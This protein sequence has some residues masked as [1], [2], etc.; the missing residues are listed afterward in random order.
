[1]KEENQLY[2]K[3][4]ALIRKQ[5]KEVKARLK[6]LG[7]M[8]SSEVDRKYIAQPITDALEEYTKIIMEGTQDS[9]KAGITTVVDA[10]KKAGGAN[11]SYLHLYLSGSTR[12]V[13]KDVDLDITEYSE[14]IAEMLKQ[15]T[16]E[17]SETTIERMTGEVMDNLEDSYKEGYGIDKASGELENVFTDMEDYELKRVARTEINGAQNRATEATEHELGI[18]YDQWWSASDD[19]VRGNEPDDIADHVHMHGQ[20]SKVGGQFSNGL[21]RPGDRTGDIAE[22]INCR[23]RLVPFLMPEGYVAPAMDYFYESDLIKIK[24]PKAVKPVKPKPKPEP[25]LQPKEKT[26][27]ML[28]ED[29][30]KEHSQDYNKLKE[31]TEKKKI[32]N[33]EWDEMWK[34]RPK[35]LEDPEGYEI[36]MKKYKEA[37]NKMDVNIKAKRDLREKIKEGIRKKVYNSEEG[38]DIRTYTSPDFDAKAVKKINKAFEEVTKLV[39]K[40]IWPEDVELLVKELGPR[41]RAYYQSQSIYVTAKEPVRIAVHEIGHFL[42]EHSPGLHKKIKAFYNMRTADDIPKWLGS[43]Y[44]PDEMFKKDKFIDKYMGKVY[45]GA[46]E[47][48]SMGMEYMV[49]NPMK[50]LEKDPGMFEFIIDIMRGAV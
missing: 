40:K 7:R 43:G 32:L 36:W 24:K 26:G 23:C 1:M 49:D 14:Q 30:T 38:Y 3:L 41:K 18:Q 20:I 2:L 25:K 35:Q 48:L 31:L 4:R 44:R 34:G 45:N 16:F 27:R 11:K 9:V 17:A 46:T 10:I 12:T 47:I 15:Q 13:L 39:D 50:L 6:G 8:P 33:K 19:R 5:N 21:S 28:R 22:W 37:A 42:E 29:I